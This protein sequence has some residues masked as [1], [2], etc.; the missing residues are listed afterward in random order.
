MFQKEFEYSISTASS[1]LKY[2][3]YH[4]INQL[5]KNNNCKEMQRKQC[6]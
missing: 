4:S 1:I 3:N 2:Y 5:I 6:I